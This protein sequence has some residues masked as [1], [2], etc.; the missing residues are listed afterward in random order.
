MRIILAQFY[1]HQP[2]PEYETIITNLRGHGHEILSATPDAQ[3]DLLVKADDQL[4]AVVLGVQKPAEKL[5]NIPLIRKLL[6][7][8]EAFAYEQR[9]RRLL[10]QLRPDIVQINPACLAWFEILPLFMPA[11]M[12]FILDFRQVDERQYTGK[13]GGLK[14]TIYRF[15]RQFVAKYIYH[16]AC[17]LHA[18]GA[19]RVLGN[20]WKKWA[21]VIP[22]GIESRFLQQQLQIKPDLPIV[23]KPITFVYLGTISKRRKLSRL[24]LA[25]QKAQAENPNFEIVF[26][27]PDAANGYYQTMVDDLNLNAVVR[28]V[29]RVP[30]EEVP[31]ILSSFDV[32][33]A[34]IPERPLDWQYHPTLKALEYRALGIPMIATDFEP[35][36][37]I[38]RDGENGL[39]VE[40]NVDSLAN[41]ILKFVQNPS[42]LAQSRDTA[43]KMRQ[44][45]LWHDVG[46]MYLDMYNSLSGRGT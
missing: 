46:M 4:I 32:A 26:I 43:Q 37:E 44:G 35:N 36:R 39:L 12:R 3:G 29:P 14:N 8:K 7:K 45:V 38:V 28:F 5:A 34:Y 15:K 23:N 22:L 19:R 42:F 31:C 41:A 13:L 1:S 24:I 16:R 25:A 17:F 33:L 9:V 21:S 10:L 11:S 18:A 30:Y 40:N 27:G 2:T 20:D 6:W